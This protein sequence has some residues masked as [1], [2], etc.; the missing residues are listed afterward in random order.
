VDAGEETAEEGR[1]DRDSGVDS[2]RHDDGDEG[3]R[4]KY[5]KVRV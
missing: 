3:K 2:V 1:S 4:E 5:C